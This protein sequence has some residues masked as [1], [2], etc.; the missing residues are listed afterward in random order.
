MTGTATGSLTRTRALTYQTQDGEFVGYLAEP[1]EGAVRPAIL[2]AHEGPG[3]DAHARYR[4]EKLAELGY[5]AF[6]CDLHGAGHVATDHD[7]TI[8]LVTELRRTPRRL[9]ERM[10]A[11]LDTLCEVEHVDRSRLAAIGYCFGGMAA[12]ELARDGAP[13]VGTVTFHG[14]LETSVPARPGE[15]KGKVLVL[16]G[17][18]D[19]LIPPE[20]IAA[21]E[22]EMD[23]AGV[24]WQVV[25]YGGVKHAF[26]NLIEAEKLAKL[27]FGY[28]ALADRR[29]WAAMRAFLSEVFE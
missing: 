2:V 11:A 21:F 25:R 19:H 5:T 14:L 20:Q 24:D 4:T 23:A 29:S 18:G 26:T 17:A 13:V 15:V 8:A 6:A 12:L 27:G 1:V 3:L 16:T 28:D 7:E 22:G 9:R 10:R